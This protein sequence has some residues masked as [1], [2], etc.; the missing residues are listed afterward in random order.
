[1][2]VALALLVLVACLPPGM[3]SAAT[4]GGTTYVGEDGIYLG[5]MHYR[6]G[7]GVANRITIVPVVANG[8]FKV[9][10]QA[11][12]LRAYGDCEQVDSQS[13]ICPWTESS[14]AIEV[15]V[16]NRNDRVQVTDVPADVRGGDG[17]DVLIG[18][19]DELFGDSGNDTLLGRPGSSDRLHGG[20]GR[21]RMEGRGAGQGLTDEFYDDE[22]DEQAHE[23]SSLAAQTPTR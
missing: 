10:E 7:H 14:P 20:P 18:D 5:T 8:Q 17:G 11:E 23:T 9:T 22:S 3:A 4:V 2:W 16:G 13:A 21:D 1:M 6:A 19:G 15:L 12:R